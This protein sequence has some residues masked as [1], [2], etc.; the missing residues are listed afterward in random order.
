MTNFDKGI[1]KLANDIRVQ[2][3]DLTTD[4]FLLL[5]STYDVIHRY[6]DMHFSNQTLSQTGFKVLNALILYGGRMIPTDISKKIFRSKHSV[7]KLIF[8][9]ESHGLVK[10]SSVGGDRRKR[11]VEI[12]DKG[13]AIAKKGN[14]YVRQRISEEVMGIFDKKEI[15][16]M[17]KMLKRLRNHTLSLIGKKSK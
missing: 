17:R 14:I 9:L 6:V 8:T 1:E 5:D 2:H 16:L 12:T 15:T 4:A 3:K 13:L 7:S 10:I 11:E